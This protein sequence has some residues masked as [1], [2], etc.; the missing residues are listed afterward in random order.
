MPLAV[1]A[2]YAFGRRVRTPRTLCTHCAPEP[3][4]LSFGHPL[5]HWA[6]TMQL[7]SWLALTLAQGVSVFRRDFVRS[8]RRGNS[9]RPRW[10]ES[11]DGEVRRGARELLP[12]PGGEGE[13]L[14][15]LNRSRWG[16][17]EGVRGRRTAIN[18]IK[19]VSTL[20]TGRISSRWRVRPLTLHLRRG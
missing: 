10:D 18:R 19:T 15:Q 4:H 2:P 17:G 1:G 14:L 3:P 7:E 11:R 9:L 13:R 8:P 12:L 5:P 16:T 20:S 6:G